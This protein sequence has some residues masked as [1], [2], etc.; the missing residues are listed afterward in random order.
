MQLRCGVILLLW[1]FSSLSRSLQS[2]SS[3]RFCISNCS[4]FA[5]QTQ[6]IVQ[7]LIRPASKVIVKF[8]QVILLWNFLCFGFRKILAFTLFLIA[9]ALL[10]GLCRDFF[11]WYTVSVMERTAR[12]VTE[13]ET[14]FIR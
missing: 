8:L 13:W 12:L 6:R 9:R 11:S 3:F 10:E 4:P 5:T 2:V 14:E 7:V 1:M